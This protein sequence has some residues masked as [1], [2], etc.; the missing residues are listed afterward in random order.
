MPMREFRKELL[1]KMDVFHVDRSFA[2]RYLN[3]GFSGGEKKRVRDL[4]DGDAQPKIAIWTR[5][6][7]AW[8]STPCAWCPTAS[9]SWLA[10]AWACCSSPT[11][12]AF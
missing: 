10:L 7:P 2:Q 5:P 4:A 8:T 1:D 6:T 11:T 9:T 12:S 3:E